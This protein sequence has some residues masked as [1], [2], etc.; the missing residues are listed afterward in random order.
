MKEEVFIV[1]DIGTSNIKCGCLNSAQHILIEKQEKFPMI[2]NENT[3]EIDV[4]LLFETVKTLIH[5]CLSNKLLQKRKVAALLITSQ[6]NTFVP[7][8]NNFI[9]LRNGIVWLDERAKDEAEYLKEQLPEFSKYSGFGE[10]LAALFVSKLLWLKKNEPAVFK[11]AKYFP[12]INEYVVYQLTD[13]F[14]TDSTSFGMSGMY[15]YV[16]KDINSKLLQIMGLTKD[17][18]PQIKKS[19]ESS[20][21]ISNEIS[22]D[23]EIS[24]RFP[25]YFCGNDQCASASG[26]GLKGAGDI[27]I[28]FGSAL[29]IF[30]ITK[31]FSNNL[32]LHQIAGKFPIS[33]DYFL[34]SYEPDFGIIVRE[35]KEKMFEAGSYDQLFQTYL[36]YPDI[37]ERIPNIS[38]N[39]LEFNTHSEAHQLCAGIIKYYI[40]QFNKHLTSIAQK[41]SINKVY[42]SGAMTQSNVLLKIIKKEVKHMIIINNQ[43]NAGLVGALNIYLLEK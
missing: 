40:N 30:S 43:E 28:N 2:H 18:F 15:D 4:V 20:A 31:E 6:A 27:S 11:N 14:Y 29:V 34:L 5:N 23:W 25:V 36:D 26:A 38:V 3:Y 41:V 17:N 37:E 8:T 33:N 16:I 19:V 32:E 35:L 9:P 10:P 21:L 13:K 12:L 7:V 22:K 39:D 42:L 1:L 24:Y